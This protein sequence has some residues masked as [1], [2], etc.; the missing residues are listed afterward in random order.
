ML[1][2]EKLFET[3]AL[4]VDKHIDSGYLFL[5]WYITQAKFSSSGREDVDVRMLGNGRPF[6]LMISICS[7]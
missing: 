5:S 6:V 3:N 4:A 2:L 1:Q 7:E